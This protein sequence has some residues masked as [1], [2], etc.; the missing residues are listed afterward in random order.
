MAK[1]SLWFPTAIYEEQEVLNKWQNIQLLDHCY[2]MRKN[3]PIAGREGWVGNTYNSHGRYDDLAASDSFQVLLDK[4]TNH[5]NEFG[6][7][8]GSDST[9][10]CDGA[11]VNIADK[12]S[13]Q[14]YHAHEGSVFSCVYYVNVNESSGS[15]RF[16]DPKYPTMLDI[17][18]SSD[19]ELTFKHVEINPVPGTLLIFR[20]YLMHMVHPNMSAESRVSIAFNFS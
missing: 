6:K 1:V 19:T 9:F 10:Q 7:L 13:F 15:I 3:A 5:V 11:W 17:K 16:L 2:N 8:H 18:R 14:E 4:V 12:G 20:S